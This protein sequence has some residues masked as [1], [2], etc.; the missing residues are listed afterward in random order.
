MKPDQIQ[1][2]VLN[3]FPAP[4]VGPGPARRRGQPRYA[5][6]AYGILT[7]L[8][9]LLVSCSDELLLA[10]QDDVERATAPRVPTIE[11]LRGATPV[12]DGSSVDYGSQP[13]GSSTDLV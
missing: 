11:I 3:P 8:A 4:R 10:I 9:F 1:A 6:A 2:P 12:T 7:V 13:T 5:V